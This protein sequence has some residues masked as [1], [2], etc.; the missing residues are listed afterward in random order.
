M[1]V[2]SL[3]DEAA[4]PEAAATGTW[5]PHEYT[6]TF[7]G[8][9]S[10]YSCDWLEEKLRLLLKK[11]GARADIKIHTHCQEPSGPSPGAEAR[12]SFYA[13]SPASSA[14]DTSTV[15]RKVVLRDHMPLALEASDCELVEQFRVEL[16]PFF[17]T[18]SIDNHMSCRGV[19][20]DS[21]GIDLRFEALAPA[22]KGGR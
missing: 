5:Q 6:F 15:W 4:A 9:H 16:L 11:A 3:A 10:A 8:T 19:D 7:T 1:A 18:R 22:G 14:G 12:L 20:N 21:A 17:T 13:L 2:A